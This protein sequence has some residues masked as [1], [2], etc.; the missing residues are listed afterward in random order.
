M[1]ALASLVVALGLAL[2]LAYSWLWLAVGDGDLGPGV[3]QQAMED[4]ARYERYMN[5]L[6][7]Q[8]LLTLLILGLGSWIMI[9]F[10]FLSCFRN[11][12][13][14][15]GQVRRMRARWAWNGVWALLPGVLTICLSIMEF[16][17]PSMT[18]QLINLVALPQLLQT[19]LFAL[20]YIAAIYYLTTFACTH[21][22][23]VAAIP[24]ARKRPWLT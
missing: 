12:I 14:Q 4:S 10:W 8:T 3:L 18:S 2:L 20:P 21:R 16:G 22:V 9:V 7:E 17:L 1:P 23:Y 13:G 11:P 6:R 15:V 5:V 24:L 19:L